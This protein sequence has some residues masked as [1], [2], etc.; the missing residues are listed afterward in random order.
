M[1][2][3]SIHLSGVAISDFQAKGDKFGVFRMKS[4]PHRDRDR[5]VYIDVLVFSQLFE[6]CS[7]YVR[8]GTQVSVNGQLRLREW[9]S[10]DGAKRSDYS[11][12]ALSIDFSNPRIGS[13]Q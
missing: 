5:P 12:A 7:Q 9:Q 10:Q 2:S 1:D 13:T 8:R 3:N 6:S 11:I 4:T